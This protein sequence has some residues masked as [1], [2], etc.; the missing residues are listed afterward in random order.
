MAHK[1]LNMSGRARRVA[2]Q[3][4]AN[5]T[6][7]VSFLT[8]ETQVPPGEVVNVEGMPYIF[9]KGGGA[10]T[11]SDTKDGPFVPLEDGSG[12]PVSVST[13]NLIEVRGVRYVAFETVS[14]VSMSRAAKTPP[15]SINAGPDVDFVGGEAQ[16]AAPGALGGSKAPF[17]YTYEWV[18]LSGGTG[19]FDDETALDAIFTP[20]DDTVPS[21]LQLTVTD[22][23]GGTATDTMWVIPPFEVSAGADDAVNTY[24]LMTLAGSATGGVPP[25]VYAWVKTVGAGTAEFVDAA[26]PDTDVYFT[27]EDEYTLTLTVTDARGVSEGDDTVIDATDVTAEEL[28]TAVLA[29]GGSE[30]MEFYLAEDAAQFR[31]MGTG[32][33]TWIGQK[34]A[35]N[36]TEAVGSQQPVIEATAGPHGRG[37]LNFTAAST[38]K[39]RTAA[40]FNVTSTERWGL[41]AVV[42]PKGSGVTSQRHVN[43]GTASA[44]RVA[45]RRASANGGWISVVVS[46]EGTSTINVAADSAANV[47]PHIHEAW[48]SN[49]HSGVFDG[50][51][52]NGPRTEDHAVT[53]NCLLGI[54]SSNGGSP[55]NFLDGYVMCVLVVEMSG[56]SVPAWVETARAR[57][58]AFYGLG[59]AP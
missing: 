25:Y 35:I 53:A 34:S 40:S 9:A 18:V 52:V 38:Q 8:E 44:D 13:S 12:S 57:I 4:P 36:A 28:T 48:C 29:D 15:L 14:V 46:T 42:Q 50:T 3:L 24:Q 45:L 51:S 49:P 33:A 16:L 20:D 31:T 5:G 55:T 56:S 11:C 6:T 37:R 41:I 23:Y 2:A 22:Y 54:G 21:Y 30:L 59:L 7:V 17:E 1:P 27:E 58:A 10:V 47:A 39:L 19:T 26:D 43:L 32:V